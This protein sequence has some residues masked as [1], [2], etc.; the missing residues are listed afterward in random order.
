MK[1]RVSVPAWTARMTLLV[2]GAL[3]GVGAGTVAL[4]GE[5]FPQTEPV[6]TGISCDYEV[7]MAATSPGSAGEFSTIRFIN[8]TRRTVEVFWLNYEGVRVYY[9]QVS[10]GASYAQTTY[11]THSWLVADRTTGECLGI[12]RNPEP[13]VWQARITGVIPP[14]VPP[15]DPVDPS[16]PTVPVD[17]TDPGL[18]DP[19]LPEADPSDPG[20]LDPAPGDA[21]APIPGRRPRSQP[22][23]RFRARLSR[24]AVRFSKLVVVAPARSVV[25]AACGPGCRM[26]RLQ[27]SG[28][29]AVSL[30]AM[31]KG[32]TLRRGA[33]I[34]IRVTQGGAG[35]RYFRYRVVRDG[36]QG[37][38]CAITAKGRRSRCAP[39]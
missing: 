7:D 17:P 2:G 16:D 19:G 21:A 25:S 29:G 15:G 8:Q 12:F 14:S 1:V 4:G 28:G 39:A 20:S 13:A 31:V 32:R 3:I 10:A 26:P 9:A 22:Y 24:N 34:H 6:L 33:A 30:T 36:L 38:S 35:G 27:V 23:V 37:V 11:P 5:P 18:P